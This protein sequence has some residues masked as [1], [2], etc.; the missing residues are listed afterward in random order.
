MKK[1]SGLSLTLW[2]ALFFCDRA[3]HGE[4]RKAISDDTITFG[5][6]Y[7]PYSFFYHFLMASALMA[8]A[9][10]TVSIWTKKN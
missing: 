1:L 10:L 7:G 5:E 3:L 2:I 6:L 4:Y 9:V 8:S